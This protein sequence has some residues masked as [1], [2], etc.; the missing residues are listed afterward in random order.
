MRRIVAFAT[1]VPPYIYAF[2]RYTWNSTILSHTLAYGFQGFTEAASSFTTDL[3]AACSLYAW[4]CSGI[5]LATYV[6]PRLLARK[7][8]RG[9]LYRVP[10]LRDIISISTCSFLMT[11]Y[12]TN[13]FF[14]HGVTGQVSHCRKFPTAASCRSLGRVSVPGL[15]TL[16]GESAHVALQAVAPTNQPMR[17]KSIIYQSRSTFHRVHAIYLHLCG[18]S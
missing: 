18:L 2:H 8:S 6:L 17:H 16:S 14:L 1:G 9:F 12:I 13:Y 7:V 11:V 10:S 15:V 3:S 5:T 4:G